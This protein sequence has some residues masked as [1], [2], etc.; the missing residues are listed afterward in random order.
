M[1]TITVG[2]KD[3]GREFSKNLYFYEDFESLIEELSECI[4]NKA[5]DAEPTLRS[6]I[7]TMFGAYGIDCGD[8]CTPEEYYAYLDSADVPSVETFP[9]LC[10]EEMLRF[11][12]AYKSPKEYMKRLVDK[13]GTPEYNTPD[14]S[15]RVKI[16]RQLM[17]KMN[18]LEGTR[19]FDED[20][21][22]VVENKYDG[23]IADIDEK[24]FDKYL[25]AR[26][27]IEDHRNVE[28]ML[29]VYGDA[30][31]SPGEKDDNLA[32]L[33][34]EF[35]STWGE[36]TAC[37]LVELI[38]ANN[39]LVKLDEKGKKVKTY[40][41]L[42]HSERLMESLEKY[43]DEVVEKYKDNYVKE[44]ECIE[45]VSDIAEKFEQ[46]IEF[47]SRRGLFDFVMTY[48]SEK[49]SD[50]VKLV[51]EKTQIA[52]GEVQTAEELR[53][54][55]FERAKAS[56]TSFFEITDNL[57]KRMKKYLPEQRKRY[58]SGYDNAKRRN[59]GSEILR[60]CDVLAAGQFKT[61]AQMKEYMYLFAFAFDMRVN[62]DDKNPY[63]D[64]KKNLF[65]DFYCDNILRYLD[66]ESRIK[67]GGTEEEPTGVTIQYKNFAEAVY[68]YW[69]NRACKK[70][71]GEEMTSY[72]KYLAAGKMIQD[73][74]YRYKEAR[75]TVETTEDKMSECY[76]NALRI[77]REKKKGTFVYRGY[78]EGNDLVG[79]KN[80]ALLKMGEKEL[81]DFILD[82]YDI[83]VSKE[84]AG[85]GAFENESCQG[86]AESTF[87]WIVDETKALSK[88]RYALVQLAFDVDFYQSA[89]E[90]FLKNAESKERHHKQLAD[91]VEKIN[92][93]FKKVLAEV[94]AGD[95]SNFT[96][97]RYMYMY[98]HCFVISRMKDTSGSYCETFD[99][100]YNDYT[101]QLSVD[102]ENCSYQP[103]S[104]K[105]LI[106]MML[107]YSA[108]IALRMDN[109]E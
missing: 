55:L 26:H 99:D 74:V 63:R 50:F 5:T 54:K 48:E 75:E 82:N 17:G 27:Y 60:I 8:D 89:K 71:S 61:N 18:Y 69:L 88:S 62:R 96:R 35:D 32:S 52:V 22:A 105:N 3:A 94:D 86:E 16:L 46:I 45:S 6:N 37:E 11:N 24:I 57:L 92:T 14:A 59:D 108:F 15:V 83:D 20:L 65:E 78:F 39:P 70:T 29:N 12:R 28:V 109:A 7:K 81:E 97:T 102:L 90:E 58:K 85:A 25:S 21:K 95:Y 23:I 38:K 104:E 2:I 44:V 80:I 73:I 49:L 9:D 47:V 93:Q 56:P 53:D 98:Y 13:L 36:K 67:S 84:Y 103:F 72:E 100:F 40:P 19:F 34:R 10:W 43:V 66:K 4:A 68:L 64:I 91:L 106:D 77:A 51:E 31:Y 87:A 101:E 79:E 1:G 33:L 107:L 30:L 41:I 76:L 42:N